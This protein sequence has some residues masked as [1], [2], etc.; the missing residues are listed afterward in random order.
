V[1]GVFEGS[2]AVL[3]ASASEIEAEKAETVATAMTKPCHLF[4]Y[5]LFLSVLLHWCY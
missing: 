2:V 5:L 1:C 3:Q 4:I